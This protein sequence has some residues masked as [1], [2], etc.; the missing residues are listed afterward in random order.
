MGKE[1]AIL[2]QLKAK[3]IIVWGKYQTDTRYYEEK[4]NRVKSIKH[5]EDAYILI[6]MFDGDNQKELWGLLTDDE[7]NRY[8]WEF[9]K[10]V[11]MDLWVWDEEDEITEESFYPWRF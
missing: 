2:E 6:N 5:P 3:C 8:K 11:L 10:Y 1:K 9:S 4:T 7:K